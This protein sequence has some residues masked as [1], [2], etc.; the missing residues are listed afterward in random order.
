MTGVSD[1]RPRDESGADR[2]PAAMARETTL[3]LSMSGPAI[4]DAVRALAGLGW[5]PEPETLKLDF[6]RTEP[7]SGWLDRAV[8]RGFRHL[9]AQT[10]DGHT[11][12]WEPGGRLALSRP[13]TRLVPE[14]LAILGA[15]PFELAAIGQVHDE[16][17]AESFRPVSFSDG[18]VVHGWACAFRGAGHDRLVS[19]RWL[20][21][22]PWRTHA[23]GETTW[24][25]FHDLDD[26]PGEALAKARVGWD[27]MGISDTGGFLQQPFVFAEDVQGVFDPEERKLKVLVPRGDVT[28]RRALELAAARHHPGAHGGAIHRTA[29]VFLREED[30]RRH[31]EML[32]PYDHEVWTFVAGD[33]V[34]LDA[35]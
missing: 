33:E 32:W 7:T 11:L 26:A 30:A 29:V 19:R 31:V 5:L 24:V 3:T 15:L 6:E 34:R 20:E 2:Y 28:P 25:E 16:W 13:R 12:L 18:H 10:D 8:A 21:R 35:P 23:Q 17:D 22:G 1:L 14:L 27:R 9:E 4:D